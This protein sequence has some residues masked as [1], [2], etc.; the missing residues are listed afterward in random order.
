MWDTLWLW[1]MG[2]V[3]GRALVAP[4]WTGKQEPL[5]GNWS[6]LSASVGDA[7]APSWWSSGDSGHQ[8]SLHGDDKTSLNR[9]LELG[10]VGWDSA[11]HAFHH[12][13]PCL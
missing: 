10:Q 12:L 13:S 3:C 7:D 6:Q 11:T 2:T 5:V 4:R 8:G 1:A 9:E